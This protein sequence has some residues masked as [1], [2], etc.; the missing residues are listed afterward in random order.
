MTEIE[1]FYDY[2]H[3]F[4]VKTKQHWVH[5]SGKVVLIRDIKVCVKEQRSEVHF[6]SGAFY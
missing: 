6:G 5:F 1:H 2:K 3:H 4:S